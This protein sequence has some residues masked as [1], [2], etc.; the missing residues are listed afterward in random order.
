MAPWLRD[1]AGKS[2]DMTVRQYYHRCGLC[3]G[4][5]ALKFDNAIKKL[6]ILRNIVDN[7]VSTS[8]QSSIRSRWT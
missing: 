5:H 8:A 6:K 4:P 7:W 2:Y 3:H 1:M